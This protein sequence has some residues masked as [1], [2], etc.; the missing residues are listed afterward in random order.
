MILNLGVSGGEGGHA[1]HDA[2]SGGCLANG[3]DGGRSGVSLSCVLM[4]D[5]FIVTIKIKRGFYFL[6][7][8]M[9]GLEMGGPWC[10]P[11]SPAAI[12]THTHPLPVQ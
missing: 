3:G 5:G 10:G 8:H 4:E 9:P 11:P 7:L 2:V 6:L 1:R 12:V